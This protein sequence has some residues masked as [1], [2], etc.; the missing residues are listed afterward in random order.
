MNCFIV[1]FFGGFYCVVF[2]V[3]LLLLVFYSCVFVEDGIMLLNMV[4]NMVKICVFEYVVYSLGNFV[5][6]LF[7]L[8]YF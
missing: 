3:Q 6:L 5:F 2:L 1:D 8:C 7:F 4:M